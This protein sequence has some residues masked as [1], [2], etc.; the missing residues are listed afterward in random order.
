MAVVDIPW[1]FMQAETDEGTHIN[2]TRKMVNWLIEIDKNVKM[3]SQW[4]TKAL[5]GTVRAAHLFWKKLSVQPQ[6]C[7]LDINP[8][9]PCTATKI[10]NGK[11]LPVL[12]HVD[13]LK[14]SHVETKAVNKFIELLTDVLGKESPL[15]ISRGKVHLIIG[16]SAF[17]KMVLAGAPDDMKGWAPNQKKN[18][19]IFF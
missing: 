16:M 14:I 17:A 6:G 4:Y 10:T 1:A 11:Q 8:Y 19:E 13:D 7:G 12:W 3:E 15:S 9:D 5:Y 18:C 2:I